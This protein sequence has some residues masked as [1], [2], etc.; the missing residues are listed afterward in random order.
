M[1]FINPH[2]ISSEILNLINE[3][4][5]YLVLVSPYVDFKNWDRIK[6]SILNAQK[7]GVQI[8][9][10]VR[11]DNS[12]GWEQI[13]QLGIKPKLIKNLHAKLYFNEKWG[14]V[15]SKLKET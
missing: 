14:V 6:V 15:T 4:G 7:R 2:Q 8:V 3:A 10:Y 11:F 13:E 12:K 9:F 5:K 1:K